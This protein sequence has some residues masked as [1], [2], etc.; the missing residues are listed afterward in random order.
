MKKPSH[1]LFFL[2]CTCFLSPLFATVQ[3]DF[4]NCSTKGCHLTQ[5]EHD[6][7]HT[8]VGEDCMTCHQTD[9]KE[10]P[11]EDEKEFSLNAT[12]PELC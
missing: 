5:T 3:Q 2:F 7:V 10:H 4:S 1:L 12:I 8:P 6:I 11:I 9:S